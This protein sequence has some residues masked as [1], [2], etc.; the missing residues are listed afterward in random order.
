MSVPAGAGGARASDAP[1][2]G[3]QYGGGIGTTS[4]SGSGCGSRSSTGSDGVVSGPESIALSIRTALDASSGTSTVARG[5][6]EGAGKIDGSGKTDVAGK[7][8][9][10]GM[11]SVAG[12]AA[13]EGRRRSRSAVARSTT[14]FDRVSSRVKRSV[15]PPIPWCAFGLYPTTRPSPRMSTC[16]EE[17]TSSN[18]STRPCGRDGAPSSVTL[19]LVNVSSSL[20]RSSSSVA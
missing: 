2:G 3:D 17:S 15:S 4:V 1:E 19:V 13:A 12:G 11:L 9:G 14:V 5:A 6:I 8:D 20:S 18:R 16:P 10:T 7:S